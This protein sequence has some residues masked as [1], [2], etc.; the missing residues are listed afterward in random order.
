MREGR[1]ANAKPS[2]GVLEEKGEMGS[3]RPRTS[4]NLFKGEGSADPEQRKD[5]GPQESQ[6]SDKHVSLGQA[7]K[8]RGKKRFSNKKKSITNY[9]V[10]NEDLGNKRPTK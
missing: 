10:A 2:F 6:E 4:E 8:D 7:R 5:C 1:G 3:H 9:R